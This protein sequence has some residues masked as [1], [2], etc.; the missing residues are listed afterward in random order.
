MNVNY[1]VYVLY[2]M[3]HGRYYIGSS[4]DP[5]KR[6]QSHNDHRNKGWTKRYAPWVIIYTEK[7][8]AKYDALLKEKWLKSG[9]GREFI[10]KIHFKNPDFSI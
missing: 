7:F 10:I 8:D 9:I 4:A 1:Y 5:Q 2:S 3:A 6:L